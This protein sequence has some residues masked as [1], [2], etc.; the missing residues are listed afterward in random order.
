MKRTQ[1]GPRGNERVI[2]G[3]KEADGTR[4]AALW[5]HLHQVNQ[6]ST[7]RDQPSHT[8]SRVSEYMEE[9]FYILLVY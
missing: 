9:F 4:P 1:G 5:L 8:H 7:K 6:P 2:S 3:G